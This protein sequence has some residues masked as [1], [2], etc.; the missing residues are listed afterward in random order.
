MVKCRLVSKLMSYYVEV[1]PTCGSTWLWNR[2]VLP[3]HSPRMSNFIL[4]ASF[5]THLWFRRI[6]LGLTVLSP[7]YPF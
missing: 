2:V 5:K 4:S 1:R 3:G 6:I 7:G